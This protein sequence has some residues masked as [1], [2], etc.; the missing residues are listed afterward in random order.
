MK[1]NLLA[2][3]IA[4][5][6]SLAI[7]ALAAETG[8]N[9]SPTPAKDT[10]TVV[11]QL[12]LAA[13]LAQMGLEQQD[14][15]LLV[16]AAKVKKLTPS[17][18]SK[19]DKKTEGTATSEAGSGKQLSADDLLAKAAELSGDNASYKALI[20]EV[21]A[22]K[23]RGA[24]GGANEHVDRV[25]AGQTDVYEIRFRGDRKAEVGV[26]GDGDTDLDLYVYDE[27]GNLICS[28]EDSSDAMYCSWTP[29][30]TGSFTIKIKNLGD[31]YN[32]YVLMTN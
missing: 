25:R 18:E 11:D 7:P 6:L 20:A 23:T 26:S 15:L 1:S 24:V 22:L 14:P 16:A 5:S 8:P 13:Q 12:T 30:W 4:L 31:V 27:N 21:S 9:S 2:S 3:A 17:Q 28:D 10:A 29:S 19:Q 32:E